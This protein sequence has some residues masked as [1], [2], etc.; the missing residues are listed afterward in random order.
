MHST[1]L[2]SNTQLALEH[3]K[4]TLQGARPSTDSH[5]LGSRSTDSLP[6][7][8]ALSRS[9][10]DTHG[11]GIPRRPFLFNSKLSSSSCTILLCM[12]PYL[13]GAIF[14]WVVRRNFPI[15]AL[16]LFFGQGSAGGVSGKT[17]IHIKQLPTGIRL[18]T[19]STLH[20]VCSDSHIFS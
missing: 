3:L 7:T 13:L 2:T 16:F 5:H 18:C 6:A 17:S 1:Q 20:T 9:C 11:T 4:L 10:P 19:L 15:F 12:Y 14:H 8:P